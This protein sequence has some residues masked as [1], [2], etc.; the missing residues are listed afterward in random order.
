MTQKTQD[1]AGKVKGNVSFP[2]EWI[3]FA[4]LF[5]EGGN[6][7]ELPEEQL[8]D[9]PESITIDG[10]SIAPD[11]VKPT[12]NQYNFSP[13]FG[14]PP[15]DEAKMAYVFLPIESDSKQEVTIG[16]G[17]DWYLQA[18]VNGTRILNTMPDGNK[19]SRVGI[20]N[21][22]INA[23]LRKG[24]N[25]LALR[26]VNG[27]NGAYL[28]VGGPDEL[29]AGDFR[30]IMPAPD[31]DLDA[32]ALMERYPADPQA[33]VHWD[34]PEGFDPRKAGLGLPIMEEAEHFELLHALPSKAPVD[35]G[36]TG[37]YESLHHGTW[38]HNIQRL[39]P[40]KDRLIGVWQNHAMDENGPGSREL[41]RV[42][43]IINARG[44]VDWNGEGSLIEPAPAPVPVRRRKEHS[45]HDAIRGTRAG[46]MFYV[47]GDR[48]FFRGSLNAFHGVTT[49]PNR[50]KPFGQIIPS[51][52]FRFGRGPDAP[53]A[54][55]VVWELGVNFY[56]EWALQKDRLQPVTPLY[57]DNEQPEKLQITPELSLPL[58]PLLPPYRDAPLL[59]E[60]TPEFQELVLNIERKKLSR[61][62]KFE[63]EGDKTVAADGNNKIVSVHGSTYCRPDGVWVALV[64]NKA[65]KAGPF[66]YSAVKPDAESLF[67]P[68]RR[69]NIFGG[70]KPAAGELPDGRC[71][72]IGNSPN[73]RNMYLLISEDG[74]QFNKTW[75]LRH[76]RLMNVTPGSMKGEGG[77]G[78]GPQYLYSVV[79]GQSLWIIY[80]ISKEHVATTRVPIPALS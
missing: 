64:E 8:A 55:F 52:H 68:P 17:A 22:L 61:K 32:E 4:P 35:E 50:R 37:R 29:R 69:S 71:Y 34:V 11:R 9:I 78:S 30:S 46:G 59:A 19:T 51:E 72:F 38:N 5:F 41:A 23:P 67:P 60:A 70:V 58:E 2:A 12:R 43:K 14:E 31:N 66:Y 36:G 28:A 56:Q 25:V 39:L 79:I 40:Y 42:G 45:D 16:M 80:S 33:P 49:E 54:G 47:V 18:W 75:L 27:A 48:L 10:D 26:F 13:F 62:P 73:R 20:N 6:D 57:K 74:R 1:V 24:R 44:E 53:R 65:S 63:A 15:Y 3:V 21:Y 76:E 7:P 77:P